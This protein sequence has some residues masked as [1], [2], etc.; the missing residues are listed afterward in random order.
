MDGS[1]LCRFTRS[2]IGLKVLMALTGLVLAGFVLAHVSGNLLVFAGEAKMNAY[3]H[4]LKSSAGVLWG[5]RAVLLGSVV[6]HIVSAIKLT[7]RRSDARP[8]AYG[9]KEPHGSTYA[10]RTMMW[11]GPILGLF[12]V[13]HLLHFTVGAVHPMFDEHNAYQNL[14]IGFSSLPVVAVYLVSMACLCL[15]LSHGVWSMMQT[16]GVNRPNWEC[17]LRRVAILYGVAVCAGFI[18]IPL[19]VLFKI[20]K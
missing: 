2:N 17:A 12:I 16:I 3:A 18:S 19:A 9:L 20:V 14:V 8:V 7:K 1:F 13:Y 4:L 6:I 10:A 5:A 11:S 15:H